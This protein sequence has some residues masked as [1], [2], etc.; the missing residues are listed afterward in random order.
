[1]SLEPKEPNVELKVIESA[2]ASLVPAQSRMDRDQVMFRAGQAAARRSSSERR[3]WMALAASFGLIAAGEAAFLSQR[4]APR[5]V[6]RIVVVHEPVKSMIAP[7]PQPKPTE[8]RNP[9][10]SSSG[11][12]FGLAQTPRERLVEQVLRYGLDGLPPSLSTVGSPS[13]PAPVASHQLLK[14]ELRKVLDPGDAS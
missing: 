4:P 14:E 2:L 11:E 5:I 13:E 8:P 6:E 10:P 7:N 9:P 12:L 1:M 3:F